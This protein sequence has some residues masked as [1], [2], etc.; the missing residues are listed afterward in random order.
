MKFSFK[1]IGSIIASTAMLTSTVALAAA[2]NFPAPF[3]VG[4]TAD[5]A[6][7]HGGENAMYTDLVA[8]SDISAHLST[9]LAQNTAKGGTTTTDTVTGEAAP[10]FTTGSRLYLND[11]LNTIKTVLTKTQLP[12]VLK[13][14]SF[15]GNVDATVASTIEIG[16][17]PLVKFAKEPTSSS[18]P[19]FGLS[20]SSTQANYL[21][22]ASVTFSKTVNLTHAD[23]KGEDLTLFGQTYTIASATSGTSLV[24]LKSAERVSLSTA[25]P[26]AEVT[27]AGKLYTVD[28]ISTS[29][30]SA[31][32]QVTDSSGTTTSKEIN[33]D[34]SKKVG[35]VTIAV[36]NADETNLQLSAT[37]VVGA[38]KVTLTAG[39]QVTI[40]EDNT[41]IDGTLVSFPG[42][43]TAS[44]TV[45]ALNKIVISVYAATSD[46]DFLKPGESFQ[47]P[48]SGSFKIN[49][50]GLSTP[51]VST[52]REDIKVS[53]SSDD[54]MTLTFTDHRGKEATAIQ[55]VQNRSTG[56]D[57][58]KD[59]DARNI[60]VLEMNP[61]YD[62]EYAVVGNE[63]EGYLLRVSQITNQS[64]GY[65]D[66]KV[67]FVDVISGETYTTATPSSEGSTTVYIGGKSYSVT[68]NG[69]STSS[70][71][72]RY[73]RIN[74]QDSSGNDVIIYPTIET[75]KGAK[76]QFYRPQIVTLNNWNGAGAYMGNVSGLI[77]PDGDKYASTTTVTPNVAGGIL[78]NYTI[79]SNVEFNTSLTSEVNITVSKLVY[80]VRSNGT[81]DQAKVYL[82]D[83]S[84]PASVINAPA[85]VIWEEKDDNTEYQAMIVTLED[86]T[87][88]SDKIGVDEVIRTWS[89]DGEWETV[90]LA[91]DSKI[92]KDADLW[93]TVVTRDGTTSD[94]KTAT[95][96][97]PDE[98]VY[99]Q[100]Y[101]SEDTASIVAGGSTG[102]ATG[103]SSLGSVSVKDSEVSSVATKNLIVVGGSCVNTVAAELL[104]VS[105]RTCGEDFTTKTGVGSGQYLIQT[106][107]RTGGKVAT[108]VAG[109]NAGDTTTAAKA[110]TT[111]V[112]DTTSGTKYTGSTS[113]DLK[114][115]VS[116]AAA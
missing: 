103:A 58:Y 3:V 55:W 53:T 31:T 74:F 19:E 111:S 98:Q 11:S 116:A 38:E 107:A 105:S 78:G 104:G 66:D 79:G 81:L 8:V 56:W 69:A 43:D 59:G 83:P 102:G 47:D 30:T 108:L 40:G 39:S 91:S 84:T 32:I 72:S 71:D 23:S 106:F 61:V 1:K 80:A 89:K 92:D 60:S 42:N 76:I 48:V 54:K 5:V 10:L 57:L 88:S 95:I 100:V 37:I 17:K 67:T 16:S 29:D 87:S 12:T 85:L 21:Y 27:V 64:S 51:I 68:Y 65:T 62:E 45:P 77:F 4:G 63:D 46:S 109:F 20:Y 97:Y 25:S 86:Y 49:F 112:V 82:H 6:L 41:V 115:V 33:E 90:T 14:S 70:Q 18:D 9:V 44:G 13:D 94:Q 28:L 26:S 75:S 24:L 34:A 73:V 36:I 99:A 110:L 93:G 114:S 35:D 7:V 52:A 50:A 22:N 96:S 113:T 101:A 2:A 15:S